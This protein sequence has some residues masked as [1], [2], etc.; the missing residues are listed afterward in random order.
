VIFLKISCR[1]LL[2]VPKTTT[3]TTTT[4]NPAEEESV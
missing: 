3:T 4:K 2:P 1:F